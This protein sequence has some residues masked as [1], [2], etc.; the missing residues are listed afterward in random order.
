[1]SLQET[2]SP[3]TTSMPFC[4]TTTQI[5]AVLSHN[6]TQD[7]SNISILHCIKLKIAVCLTFLYKQ[8][9]N[10]TNKHPPC[11]T[12]LPHTIMAAPLVKKFVTF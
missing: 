6:T 4:N 5:M 8:F 10:M 3:S 1:V 11:R 9:K 7:T 2:V 12:L